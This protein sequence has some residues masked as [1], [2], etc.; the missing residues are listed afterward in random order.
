M[1]AQVP[2]QQL[3]TGWTNSLNNRKG[4]VTGAFFIT[5]FYYYF[6]SLY[7]TSF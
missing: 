4:P 2:N 3:L 6:L 7:E 5:S 1:T